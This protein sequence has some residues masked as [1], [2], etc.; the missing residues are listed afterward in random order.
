MKAYAA[1]MGMVVGAVVLAGCSG[2]PKGEQTRRVET[3]DTTKAERRSPQVQPAALSEFADGASQQLVAD[4][5]ALPE[6]NTGKRV[7][8]VFGDIVNKT[9][10]VST[11]DFEAFRSKIRAKLL[12]SNVARSKV[13]WFENRARMDELRAREQPVGGASP[14]QDL[15]WSHTYFLNGEMYRVVRGDNNDVNLYMLNWQL[16]NADTRELIWQHEY[17]VK[18]TPGR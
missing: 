17:E 1:G 9:V 8:V 16:T 5:T 13:R 11:A 3:S 15:E 7:N 12:S 2:P 14:S 10:I 4:I 18:Q 6:F